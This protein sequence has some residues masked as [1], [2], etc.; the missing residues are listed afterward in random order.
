MLACTAWHLRATL[1]VPGRRS[2]NAGKPCNVCKQLR[3]QIEVCS[4]SITVVHQHGVLIL[5]TL[6]WQT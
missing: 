6:T 4:C 1:Y 2:L 5:V 3:L